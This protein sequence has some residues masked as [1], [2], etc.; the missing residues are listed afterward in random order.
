M[1]QIGW[2]KSYLHVEGEAPVEIGNGYSKLGAH[3][4]MMGMFR[5][6]VEGS[7][8]RWITNEDAL[9]SSSVIEAAY[10]SM[11]T[12]RWAR[13]PS[14]QILAVR[15][16]GYRRSAGEAE[17]MSDV[18]IHPTAIV[19][20]DVPDRPGHERLGQRPHPPWRLD[21]RRV[22]RRREDRTSPTM[23]ASAIAS[24][25]TRLCTSA[26]RSRSRTA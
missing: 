18:R 14:A 2:K 16:F 13:V 26:R 6:L 25:S 4:R 21:R 1:I 8:E 15:A 3:K 24:R 20:R 12:S 11:Q 23:S 19:E 22:H 5:D 9:A 17:A 10:R 7:K